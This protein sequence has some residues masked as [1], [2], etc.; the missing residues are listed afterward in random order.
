LQQKSILLR[1]T[2]QKQKKKELVRIKAKN[3]KQ[4][5]K[6]SWG[7]SLVPQKKPLPSIICSNLQ[8]LIPQI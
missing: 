6:V 7:K 3:Q 8:V 2:K 5:Q 1:K 4:I